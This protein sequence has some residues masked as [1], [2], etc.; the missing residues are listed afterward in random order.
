MHFFGKIVTLG[1]KP[2]TSVNHEKKL[3]TS[4]NMLFLFVV[5]IRKY[6]SEVIKVFYEH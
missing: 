6:A 5:H 3:F 2:V 1:T 4:N